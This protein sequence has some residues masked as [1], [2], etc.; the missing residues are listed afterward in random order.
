MKSRAMLIRWLHLG[1]RWLGMGLGV[2]VLLWFVS[3]VV[4]LFVARPQLTEPERLRGLPALEMSAVKQSPLAAWQVLGLPDWPTAVRLN[5]IAGRPAYHFLVAKRWLTV[6]ATTGLPR[7][8][9]TAAEAQASALAF[10]G[11]NPDSVAEVQAVERDQ[12]TVY[13]RF[14]AL[15]P[16]YQVKVNDATGHTLYVSQQT[17]EVALDT[18]VW[19]RAW[20]WL[21]SVTHWLY[22]TPL[23]QM[24]EVWRNLVLCLSFAALLLTISGLVLGIQRL[25]LQRRYA[26]GQITPYRAGWKRWHHLAGLTGGIFVL[27]WLLSGWLSLAPFG[28]LK[29]SAVTVAE[30]QFLA[31]GELDAEVLARIPSAPPGEVVR[32]IQ[33]LRFAGQPYIL[34]QSVAQS[35][36]Q[37]QPDGPVIANLT[38][39]DVL[40]QVRKLQ[41]S[42]P[43]IAADWLTAADENYYPHRHQLRRLP[44]VRVRLGDVEQSVFYIDPTTARLEA[45]VDSASRW[46]RWLFN[47]LHR[48]DFPPLSGTGLAR[49]LLVILLSVAGAALVLAGCILGW[50][51]LRRPSVSS[52]LANQTK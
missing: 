25:R 37:A 29:G 13:S 39:D 45:R 48:L 16:F 6:D 11:N 8:T 30:Q 52:T 26:S 7:A 49:D 15:R 44:V 1:H 36:L 47:A 28:L 32:E 5:Q 2:V 31:G 3:G 33:W 10:L 19:E 22:F 14:N 17:G 50:Q 38:L 9:A 51:R 41:P 20:N 21:G 4:M 46:H 18:E 24:T 23:R 35:R 27:T 43:V 42:A 12:W 34:L 40:A